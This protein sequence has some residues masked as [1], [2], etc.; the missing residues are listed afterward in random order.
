[1]SS[2]SGK[3]LGKNVKSSNTNLN[4]SQTSEVSDKST[5]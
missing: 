5:S 2:K 3:G 1:M 4:Q